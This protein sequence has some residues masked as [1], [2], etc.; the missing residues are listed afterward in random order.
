MAGPQDIQRYPRGLIDLLGMRATGDTPHKL[1]PEISGGIEMLELYV[2]DRMI[3]NASAG[4]APVAALGNYQ[5]PGLVVPDRELWLIFELTFYI[6]TI[7]AAT[8][9]RYTGGILRARGS[10]NVFSALLPQVAVAAGEQGNV[11]MKFERPVIGLPGNIITANVNQLTGLPGQPLNA[12][13]WYCP[14][15]I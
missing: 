11:G 5:I 14:I 7:A 1:A 12:S 13:L 4:A 2:N 15:G 3:P 6:G 10:G 8:A 9:L